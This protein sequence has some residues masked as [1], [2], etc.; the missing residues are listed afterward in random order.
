MKITKAMYDE[1]SDD[2]IKAFHAIFAEHKA[3]FIIEEELPKELIS[4]DQ[5]MEDDQNEKG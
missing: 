5:F 1:A 2:T 4:F 3:S